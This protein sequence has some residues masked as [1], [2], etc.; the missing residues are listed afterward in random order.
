MMSFVCYSI[1]NQL[2]IIVSE[3]S[4]IGWF[5]YAN[6]PGQASIRKQAEGKT[7]AAV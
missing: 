3:F 2:A 7:E 1:Q 4:E 5:G 6:F